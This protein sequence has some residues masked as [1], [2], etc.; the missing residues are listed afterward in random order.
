M[1]ARLEGRKLREGFVVGG[2][3]VNIIY[4]VDRFR[5]FLPNR[6]LNGRGL[7]QFWGVRASQMY[8]AGAKAPAWKTEDQVRMHTVE[9]SNSLH[10]TSA[11][12][13]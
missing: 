10:V 6:G 5:R 11:K 1:A 7:I 2:R 3:L 9:V 13:S 4:R 12:R 8:P